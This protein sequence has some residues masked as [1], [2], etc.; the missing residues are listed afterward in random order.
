MSGVNDEREE[1]PRKGRGEG[2]WREK[3]VD[4]ITPLGRRHHGGGEGGVGELTMVSLVVR[5]QSP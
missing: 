2:P 4:G 3:S 1:E 5:L